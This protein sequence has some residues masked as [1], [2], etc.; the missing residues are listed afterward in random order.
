MVQSLK[1]LSWNILHGGGSRCPQILRTIADSQAD[2][3]T[4]QEFRHGDNKPVLIDGLAE[5][6]LT[7]VYAPA[8]KTARENSLLIASRLP[9]QSESFPVDRE[10]QVHM[11][12]SCIE[13]SP[14]LSLNLICVHFPQKRAQIPLFEALLELPP[15]WIDEHSLLIGDFNCGIPFQDSDTKTFYATHLFQALLKNGW[16][17]AWR[18]RHLEDREFSWVSARKNNGFR[19]DHVLASDKLN[20]LVLSAE[21]NHEVR[22][23]KYS[24]HSALLIELDC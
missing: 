22:E 5:M 13:K 3:V 18:E 6:G 12:K 16:R 9:L 24:D 4:L 19:Y 2:I 11:L 20:Q 8:T 17:D 1:I 7:S 14:L 15:D 23:L 10:G 21:Y